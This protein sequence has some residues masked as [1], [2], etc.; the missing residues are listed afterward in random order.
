MDT[1]SRIVPLRWT[2]E[3][4]EARK[5]FK[6]EQHSHNGINHPRCFNR[7]MGIEERKGCIDIE[8]GALDADFDIM[9][10]WALKT[11][12]KDEVKFDH[13]NV[14]DFKKGEY[15]ARLVA[16]CVKAMWGYDRLIGHYIGPNRFDIPFIRSRYLWLKSRGL[17]KGEP[18]PK[19]GEMWITDT[20][21]M[22]KRLLK[23]TSRRQ[24]SV[25]N[26]IQGKDIKTRIDK[27]YWMAIKYGNP[28]ARKEAIE[29]IRD[30]NQRD[31][32]QLE[33]NY[34]TM[35]PYVK[36]CQSSI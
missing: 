21:S 14:S 5:E 30:H 20:Y 22:A 8:A 1:S 29:Y 11:V 15:D 23:I 18:F 36:E 19:H 4:I 10:S 17:Y 24:D 35:L 6:C 3:E 27:D 16:T 25:A 7:E 9:L 13:L 28:Q 33:Q 12:G 26:T 34:L 2:Q 31:V 32:E